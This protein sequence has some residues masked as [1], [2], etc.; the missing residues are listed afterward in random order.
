MVALEKA[1]LVPLVCVGYDSFKFSETT[2]A[3]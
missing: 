3:P 1:P 2:L